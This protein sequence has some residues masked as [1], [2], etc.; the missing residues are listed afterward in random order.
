[1][2]TT[3]HAISAP[4]RLVPRL[5]IVVLPFTNLGNDPD[6]EYF[7]DGITED[8]TTDLSQIPGMV[9]ISRNTAFAYRKKIVATKQIGHELSVR[10]LLEGSVRRLGNQI[11]VNAQLIDAET[12]SH[13]SAERF[14]GD[15]VDLFA[16]QEITSRIALAF[17]SELV[18]AE[19][20]RP[21]EHPDT[22]DYILRGRAAL[23]KPPTR[24]NYADAIGLFERALAFDPGSV[25]AQSLLASTLAR[26]VLDQMNASAASGAAD[27]VRAEELVGQALAVSPGSPRAHFAKGDLL[28]AQRQFAEA[29]PEY[30][31]VLASNRNAVDAIA[32]IGR[33]KIYIGMID[34]AIPL[35]EQAF[36]LSPRDP[37]IGVWYVWIAQAYLLQSHVDE[38]IV[39]LEKARSANPA[40][41]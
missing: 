7:A 13:V 1:M 10:Y 38:A 41:S 28:C 3:Q 14:V 23:S 17:G 40:I 30:K 4:A 2:E 20:A 18:I 25:E 11:R 33:A 6:Q 39:W 22:L 29:I 9:V 5:S 21:T 19:A 24:N 16:L 27:I 8:L 37:R 31:S 35:E 12:D 34:E 26:R 15:I 32:I 36:R